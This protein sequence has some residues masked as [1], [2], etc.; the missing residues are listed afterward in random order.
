MADI[1]SPDLP[2]SGLAGATKVS[3][4]TF[5]RRI[6]AATGMA[7]GSY[8]R[9]GKLNYARQ[10]LEEGAVRSVTQAA[11]ETSFGNVSYFSK[12]FEEYFEI[13]PNS[14]ML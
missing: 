8:V 13:N 2:V 7:A 11:I 12:L 9:D 3:E 6:K 10:L 4:R 5:Q 14:Y 1:N